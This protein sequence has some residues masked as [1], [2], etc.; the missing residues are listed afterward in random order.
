MGDFD[1]PEQQVAAPETKKE[2]KIIKE[3]DRWKAS[4]DLFKF[5]IKESSKLSYDKIVAIRLE[6]MG[7]EHDRNGLIDVVHMTL[8]NTMIERTTPGGKMKEIIPKIRE[9]EKWTTDYLSY[10]EGCV[11]DFF[12]VADSADFMIQN[13]QKR[14][15]DVESHNKELSEALMRETEKVP[16]KFTKEDHLELW[17]K[18]LNKR[19]HEYKTAWRLGHKDEIRAAE[20]KMLAMCEEDENKKKVVKGIID[21]FWTAKEAEEGKKR[22]EQMDKTGVF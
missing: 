14:I 6:L 19:A 8:K 4:Y 1:I 17:K 3:Y 10:I 22:R 12:S 18:E 20:D 13:L 11:T 9:Y 16:V 2:I 15:I 21:A 5:K 7:D